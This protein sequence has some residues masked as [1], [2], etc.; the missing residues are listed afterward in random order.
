MTSRPWAV[1]LSDTAETYAIVRCLLQPWLSHFSVDSSFQHLNV[2]DLTC[3]TVSEDCVEVDAQVSDAVCAFYDSSIEG[4]HWQPI[5]CC[6]WGCT[7]KFAWI[8]IESGAELINNDNL[9]C[10]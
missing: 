2:F 6:C 9:Y 10:K 3:V 8:E 5:G 1:T 7:T 4:E